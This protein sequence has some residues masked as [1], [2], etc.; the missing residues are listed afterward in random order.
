MAVEVAETVALE[1]AGVERVVT[2]EEM[3]EVLVGQR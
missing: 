1:S 2:A 3:L